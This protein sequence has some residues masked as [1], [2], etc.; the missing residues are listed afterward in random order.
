MKL[1]ISSP[2]PTTRTTALPASR[3]TSPL[4]KRWRAPLTPHSP[5][6]PLGGAHTRNNGMPR[7]QNQETIA[8]TLAGAT[9]SYLPANLLGSVQ[10]RRKAAQQTRERTK[11]Q[12]EAQ[13]L[14]IGMSC[15]IGQPLSRQRSDGK[16]EHPPEH[17]AEE[18]EQCG[19][20]EQLAHQSAG[21]RSQRA[22]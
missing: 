2:A 6:T 8:E 17:S 13:H 10:S 7:F 9:Y 22:A 12:R 18:G 14:H 15:I 11:R 16:S 19:F 5:P 4:R 21:T 3:I 1:C 20:G